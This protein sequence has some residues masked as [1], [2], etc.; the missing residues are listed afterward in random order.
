MQPLLTMDQVLVHIFGD[1]FLQSDYMATNKKD[2]VFPALA[3]AVTYVLPFLLLTKSLVALLV[4]SG[5]HFAIDHWGLARYLAWLKNFLGP[6]SS[7]R[8]WKECELTGFSPD[9]PIWLTVWLTIIMDNTL[10]LLINALS[11]RYL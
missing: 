1:Y 9:R 2:K 8:P 11:I 5:T 10:H 4:I 3:H 7:R 6:K